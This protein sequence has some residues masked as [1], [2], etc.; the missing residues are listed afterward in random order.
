MI[1]L[2]ATVFLGA[3]FLDFLEAAGFLG[4]A[5]FFVATVRLEA[6]V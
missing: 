4:A 6:T 5:A 3:G 2:G 1:L